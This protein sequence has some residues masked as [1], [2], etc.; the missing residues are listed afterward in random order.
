MSSI[1]KQNWLG[2][3]QQIISDR[4]NGW[5]SKEDDTNIKRGR[6]IHAAGA[7]NEREWRKKVTRGKEDS[8]DNQAS[9]QLHLGKVVCIAGGGIDPLEKGQTAYLQPVQEISEKETPSRFQ[10]GGGKKKNDRGEASLVCGKE[11]KTSARRSTSI[12]TKEIERTLP[13]ILGG[14]EK[15]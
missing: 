13:R 5:V 12:G 6:G 3:I 15:Y 9:G 10:Q 11:K 2:H 4:E 14:G 8:P 7:L 1:P